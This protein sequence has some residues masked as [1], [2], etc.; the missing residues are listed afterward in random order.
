MS[1]L[2]IYVAVQLTGLWQQCLRDNLSFPWQQVAE[3]HINYILTQIIFQIFLSH[4]LSKLHW[5]AFMLASS[6]FAA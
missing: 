6:A 1:G 3:Y 5:I 2:S 4:F